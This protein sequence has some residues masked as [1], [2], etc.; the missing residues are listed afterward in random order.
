M[1]LKESVH[2]VGDALRHLH[3]D[4]IHDL[5]PRLC[6]CVLLLNFMLTLQSLTLIKVFIVG[7]CI[8][9]TCIVNDN[10]GARTRTALARQVHLGALVIVIGIA[11]V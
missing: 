11:G 7:L 4:V 3:I 6:L 10:V 1:A 5:A 8:A 9:G 2:P